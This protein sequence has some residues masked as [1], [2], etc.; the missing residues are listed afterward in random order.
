MRSVRLEDLRELLGSTGFAAWWSDWQQVASALRDARARHADLAAQAELMSLRSEIAQRAAVDAF[1]RSGEVDDEGTRWSAQAQAEEN[2][3][4]ALVGEYEE[5]RTRT[6]D[7]WVRLGGAEKGLE[8]RRDGA[9]RDRKHAKEALAE[10]ERQREGLAA[11]YGA[12]DRKR[13]RLWDDVESAWAASFERS[14]L[15]AEHGLRARWSR[16][17]A[18]RLFGE[19]EER[20]TRSRQLAADAGA[21]QRELREAEARRDTL[22]A[23][24]RER[25]D[26]LAGEAFLYWRHH[27]D[28]R[29]AYAVALSD[30]PEGANLPVKSLTIYV[31]GRQRGTG[32][33]ELPRDGAGSSAEGRD[34]RIDEFLARRDEASREPTP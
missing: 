2:H 21:A 16:R 30:E 24:A 12:A 22:R 34:R 15:A 11:E 33:L 29:S 3:A 31:V 14:L 18:E 8:E 6:S 1:T 5:Q 23:A 13:A 32:F 27:D 9:G 28:P 20:R 17:D 7:L 19:A 25:F 4:L 26:C 10:A